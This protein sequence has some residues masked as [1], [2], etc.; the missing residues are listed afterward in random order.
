M[1]SKFDDGYDRNPKIRAVSIFAESLHSVAIRHCAAQENDGVFP[2]TDLGLLLEFAKVPVAKR[3]VT[4]REALDKVLLHDHGD[5]YEVHDFLDYNPSHA[6]LEAKRAGGASRIAGWRRNGRRN[7]VGNGACNG[8]T[9]AVTTGVGNGVGNGVQNARPDP[10]T[11]SLGSDLDPLSNPDPDRSN[12]RAK[13]PT[14]SDWCAYFGERH[15]EKT[16]RFYGR[17]EADARAIARLADLFDGAPVE[18]LH[19]D[20][21]ARERIVDE[22]LAGAEPKTVAAGWSFSFFVAQFRGLAVPPEKRPKTLANGKKSPMQA[23]Y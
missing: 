7:K 17:G 2:K 8:V 19:A 6:E 21:D 23:R 11:L 15:R 9:P 22:F 3:S 4:L 5:C 18:Q 14:A 12:A 10:G 13:L 1:W 20:W 16:G